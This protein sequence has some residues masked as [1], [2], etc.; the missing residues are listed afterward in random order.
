MIERDAGTAVGTLAVV[1]C[2]LLPKT[3]AHRTIDG[4]LTE[5]LRTAVRD[6]GMLTDLRWMAAYYVYGALVL[7][8]LPLWPVALVVDGVGCG[9]LH[10]RAV[11][12]PWIVR[13]ADLAANW[14]TTVLR[15]SPH[16][17]PAA[18][19]EQLTVTRAEAIAAHGAELRRQERTADPCH[20]RR[21]GRGG[22]V[23]WL[24]SARVRRRGAALDGT[25]RVSNPAG[26]PTVI[27]VEL[28]CVW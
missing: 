26:R 10:R 1:D 14:S 13:L 12:L 3:E 18:R 19:V 20:R 22:R 27:D 21:P 9:L 24:G 2:R 17:L 28:P 6:P 16:A 4:P 25:V 8:A 7:F 23:R 5:R 11:V 15:P